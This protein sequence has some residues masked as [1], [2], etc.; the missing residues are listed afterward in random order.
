VVSRVISKSSPAAVRRLAR[1]L[2]TTRRRVPRARIGQVDFGDFTETSPISR[3]FGFDRGKPVD[4]W[5]IERFLA[6][7]AS[8]IRGR[9]L[10][11]AG[12]EYT[13]RFGGDA[14]TRSDVL[15]VEEGHD[16]TIVGDLETGRGIPAGSFDAIVLTQTLQFVFDVR[17][18]AR[19]LYGALSPGGVLL[20][21]ATGI[22]QVSRHDADRWGDYWR[23]T[24][25]S[26][27]RVLGE[28]FGAANVEVRAHG[29]VKVATAFLQGLSSQDLRTADLEVDDPD[30]ELL[31]TARAVRR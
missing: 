4:R 7:H 20:L 30:Y 16:A 27:E 5:Y 23:F 19:A 9:V 18:A 3:S 14:I 13:E 24:V 6:A 1:K 10:E 2:R 31:L 25:Q 8:D 26:L 22:S 15:H 21:T 29:N 12:R 17:A 11:V 28:Q